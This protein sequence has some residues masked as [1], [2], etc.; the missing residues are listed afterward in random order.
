MGCKIYY[1]LRCKFY[2]VKKALS[3]LVPALD[4]YYGLLIQESLFNSKDGLQ[5]SS[6]FEVDKGAT[7][8]YPG[9]GGREKILKKK[10]SRRFDVK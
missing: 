10:F 3:L 7:I 5:S 9:G 4:A 1:C 8:R 2:K 6:T